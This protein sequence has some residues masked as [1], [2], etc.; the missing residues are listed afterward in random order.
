M[1]KESRFDVL[2]DDFMIAAKEQ[3]RD[4]SKRRIEVQ[5]V[6][7]DSR[8]NF[9][10]DEQDPVMSRFTCMNP[11]CSH[12]WKLHEIRDMKPGERRLLFA[13][14]LLEDYEGRNVWPEKLC[15]KTEG[16][17]LFSSIRPATREEII[18]SRV[19]RLIS[20]REES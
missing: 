15:D 5:T 7:C 17:K 20:I 6:S 3:D 12:Q 4:F 1:P 9:S 16:N 10:L 19:K 2:W 18:E 13:T 11:Y 14:V 8:L